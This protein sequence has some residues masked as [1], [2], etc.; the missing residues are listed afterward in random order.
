MLFILR[1]IVQ[2]RRFIL[3]SGLLTAVV[4]AG[5]SLMLPKWYTATTSIFPPDA[6]NTMSGIAQVLQ[7][8][9]QIPILAPSA[10][11][12]RPNTIYIDIALSRTIGERIIEEFDLKKTYNAQLM[13][14]ALGALRS[15]T[16]FSLLENGLLKVS[17]EDRDP[18][19]AAAVA[20]RYVDLLDEF[21]RQLN[22]GRASKTREFVGEQLSLHERELRE[23]EDE[24]RTFQQT[25]EALQLD[26]QI[27]SAI[28]LVASLTA[29]AVALEIDLDILD[30]YA[31]RTSEEYVR[32]RKEF[33][34]ILAQLEKFKT[35]SVRGDSDPIRSYFPA[36]DRLPEVTLEFARRVRRVKT[37]EAVYR[38]LVEEYE[39]ARIEEARDTPTIQVLDRATVPE[40]RSRPRRTVLV[41]L[42]G[43]LGL[44]W[45]TL[46][47]LFLTVWREDAHGTRAALGVFRPIASDAS[48]LF[49]F[50]KRS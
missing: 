40:L 23:A 38:L 13:T 46:F 47:A 42:G 15:H 2:W 26:Q 19:R 37:E 9:L 35:D 6:G 29:E 3:V 12:A 50:R 4:T 48:R 24:L 11:G 22:I 10:V 1:T 17:F 31:S 34:E 20:N 7:Q 14:D 44:G 18:E 32:K 21:N 45:S 16:T 28:D 8:S 39:K 30:Q 27:T 5:V 36:F 33:D 41:L 43:I 49:R 25:H